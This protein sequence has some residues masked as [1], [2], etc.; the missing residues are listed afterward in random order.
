MEFT[1]KHI[2]EL[3]NAID[4]MMYLEEAGYDFNK[5]LA[6]TKKKIKPIVENAEEQLKL[7]R[8]SAKQL[9]VRY[10]DK[11][12]EGKPV[13][14]NNQNGAEEYQGLSKGLKPEYDAEME[15]IENDQKAV[16]EK[17]EEIDPEEIEKKKIPKGL[18][19]IYFYYIQDFIKDEN[20]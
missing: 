9:V 8:E 4:E 7:Q 3:N 10:C 14:K 20:E 18:K 6:K 13:I 1:V 2:I 15:K 16:L 12:N 11:D 17:K 19:G 5:F